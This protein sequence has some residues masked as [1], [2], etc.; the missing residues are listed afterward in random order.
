MIRPVHQCHSDRR[1]ESRAAAKGR[2]R[3]ADG[4][5]R[6]FTPLRCVQNDRVGGAFASMANGADKQMPTPVSRSGERGY[7]L[8]YRYITLQYGLYWSVCVVLSHRGREGPL[9]CWR[10]CLRTVERLWG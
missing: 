5:F 7:T 9:T 6:F 4:D 10:A 3:V 2:R 1:E 8:Q